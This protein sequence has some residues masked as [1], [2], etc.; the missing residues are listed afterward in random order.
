M[1]TVN[2]IYKYLREFAPEEMAMETDNVGFLI[3]TGSAAVTK[4][5]ISL[6]ITTDVISEALEIGA[7]LIVAHHPMFFSL[8]SV[9]DTDVTGKKILQMLSSGLSAICMHTNL[10]AVRGGVNDALAI[11][12]GISEKGRDAETLSNDKRLPTGETVS[13]GRVGFLREPCSMSEYLKKLKT[14]LNTNG[15]RY[16]DAGHD[17]YK[18]A[19][20]AGS[21]G[22]EWGN[23]IK[24]G[25]DTFVTGEVKYHLFLEAKE[26]GINIVEGDHFC[27]ENPVVDVLKEK[28][29]NEFNDI[30]I[31]V[32]KVHKQ[33][34][35][36]Y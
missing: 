14:T 19:V 4:I 15:I 5:L 31:L 8:Q 32:S 16:Y 13:L 26:L 9:T 30:E 21:G 12:A 10:D 35:N 27:T 18:V 29:S 1:P 17:V 3:G 33:T 34:I 20:S 28:L 22:G 23:A 7:E 36:F 2:E 11:A 24:S 25:C 6:D